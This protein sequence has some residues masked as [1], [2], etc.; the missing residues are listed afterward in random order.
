[1][2]VLKLA[3]V[4]STDLTV[5][6][7]DVAYE[8]VEA[9]IFNTAAGCII[10]GLELE[11]VSGGANGID[12]IAEEE[13]FKLGVPTKI[14]KPL[15]SQW[16]DEEITD[17]SG[18]PFTLTGY[19]SRNL[20]IAEYCDRLICIRSQSSRTYGSGWTADRAEE[21]GKSVIRLYI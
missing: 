10:D 9:I 3:I 20:Q 4:G 21:M 19:R 18:D 7:V 12:L 11:V 16:E 15:I 17:C 2:S 8:L 13:A 6:Q 1:M 14:F 5:K